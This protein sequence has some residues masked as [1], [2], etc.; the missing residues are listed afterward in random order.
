MRAPGAMLRLATVA[1]ALANGKR[2][3]G[4]PPGCRH[5]KGGAAKDCKLCKANR[6]RR[7]YWNKKAKAGVHNNTP[8]RGGSSPD[9]L[10]RYVQGLFDA[11]RIE[12]PLN[13][14]SYIARQMKIQAMS[15]KEAKTL[16]P[17]IRKRRN[18]HVTTFK[19]VEALWGD[20]GI[21]AEAVVLGPA[22]DG[23]RAPFRMVDTHAGSGAIGLHSVPILRAAARVVGGSAPAWVDND[24]NT[25]KDYKPGA[26]AT[27][28][29]SDAVDPGENAW[30][31]AHRQRAEWRAR[32]VARLLLKKVKWSGPAQK[33]KLLT[34]CEGRLPKAL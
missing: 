26:A 30:Q 29:R 8:R 17:H 7:H 16:K 20:E 15:E 25:Y 12:V 31:V 34:Y 3:R 9:S 19:E 11:H 2:G 27:L 4:R 18:R 1:L 24:I 13:R 22:A 5:V 32:L 33:N 6:S 10:A 28:R 23:S 21:S 14:G